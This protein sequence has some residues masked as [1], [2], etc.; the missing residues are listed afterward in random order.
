LRSSETSRSLSISVEGEL[1]REELKDIRKAVR[2][3]GRA[4][5]E[6]IEGDVKGAARQVEKLQRLDTLSQVQAEVEVKRE[7]SVGTFAFVDCPAGPAPEH[8]APSAPKQPETPCAAPAP[9]PT[10]AEAGD[11]N[12]N[13]SFLHKLIEDAGKAA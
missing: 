10:P 8:P 2:T 7:V 5:D 11:L 3:I 1:S 9:P 12:L 13:E 6:M 4:A